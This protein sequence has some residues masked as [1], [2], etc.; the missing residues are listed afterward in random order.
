MVAVR[1]KL[2]SPLLHALLLIGAVSVLLLV[3]WRFANLPFVWRYD[4]PSAHHALY[5]FNH[6]DYGLAVT[7]G[8]QLANGSPEVPEHLFLANHHPPLMPLV[9][10]ASYKLFG[11]QESA[12]RG[13]MIACSALSILLLYLA[14]RL[15]MGRRVALIAALVFTLL[16]LNLVYATK[17]NHEPMVLPFVLGCLVAYAYWLRRPSAWRLATL[18]L[19]FCIG[20]MVGWGAYYVAGLIPAFHLVALWYARKPIRKADL[21]LLVLPVLAVLMFALF[22][23]HLYWFDPGSVHSLFHLAEERTG[24]VVPTDVGEESFSNFSLLQRVVTRSA[25]LFT[26]PALA[27]AVAG[28]V[29]VLGQLGGG[30][31]GEQPDG[32]ALVLFWAVGLAHILIFRHVSWVHEFLVYYLMVPVSVTV[33]WLLN[34][35]LERLPGRTAVSV[36]AAFAILFVPLA[37]LQ[38][39]ETFWTGQVAGIPPLAKYLKE[40]VPE[41]GV[42]LSTASHH[43]Y[44]H[45]GVALY[46]RRDVVERIETRE[47]LD[48]QR[49]WYKRSPLFLMAFDEPSASK[50]RTEELVRQM[51]AEFAGEQTPW[52]KLYDLSKPLQQPQAAPAAAPAAVEAQPQDAPVA[53]GM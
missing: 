19:I 40:R 50:V 5:A 51:D 23:A 44:L 48:R 32:L 3:T 10:A 53:P 28:L 11:L 47:Q 31:R 39:R 16:P 33:G 1:T 37:L 35:A 20:T 14:V 17:V 4:Y 18:S 27:L 46:A 24:A 7:K 41:N 15:L 8:A 43:P 52:G 34:L 49:A 6:L 22:V 38:A 21:S 12:A 2:D 45:P 26:L 9:L 30:K 13:V 36:V 29:L 42:I 25:L